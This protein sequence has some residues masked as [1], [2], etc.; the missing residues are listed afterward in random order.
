MLCISVI[1]DYADM[2][3]RL[4]AHTIKQVVHC[5][6]FPDVEIGKASTVLGLHHQGSSS[7]PS[8]KNNVTE[9]SS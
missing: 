9:I 6:S 2:C 5:R 7:L 4:H 1:A 3:N 8:H